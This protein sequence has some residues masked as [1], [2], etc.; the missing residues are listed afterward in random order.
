MSI[1]AIL[2]RQAGVISRAQ[3]L[4]AGITPGAVDRCVRV[5]HWLPLHPRVYLVGV[6]ADPDEVRVRSALLWAGPAAVLGGAAA[7]WWH[8]LLGSA[9]T[10]LAITV[11]GRRAGARP[12]VLVHRRVLAAADVTTCR[13]I[14]VTAEALTAVEAAVEL[15]PCGAA[16]LDR[17]LRRGVG[18]G[19]VEEALRRNPG[20]AA[21]SRVLAAAVERRARHIRCRSPRHDVISDTSRWDHGPTNGPSGL[22]SG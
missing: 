11:P 19:D 14:A 15:G 16:L 17:W 22:R 7:A 20:S 6:P 2:T 18:L 21:A 1:D 13:G 5:R 10:T 4:A 8:G 12:G 3:A 9:P